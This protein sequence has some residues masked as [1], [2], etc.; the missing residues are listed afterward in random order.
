MNGNTFQI[1][2]NTGKLVTFEFIDTSGTTVL[3][4]GNVQISFNST[5]DTIQTV[6]TDMVTAINNAGLAVTATAAGV[7]PTSITLNG[8]NYTFNVGTT[9]FQS[10]ASGPGQAVLLD[11]TQTNLIHMI[12]HARGRAGQH[13]RSAALLGGRSSSRR[14]ELAAGRRAA[15]LP[16][17]SQGQTILAGQD[18]TGEGVYID[19]IIVGF[20]GRGE[21]ITGDYG[22]TRPSTAVRGPQEH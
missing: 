6:L 10:T 7:Q 15:A 2:D 18:N 17:V 1:T 19:D 20:T 8:V 12:D 21:M 22:P 5:T 9:P 11:A 16:T 14:N 4:P 13:L 3:T